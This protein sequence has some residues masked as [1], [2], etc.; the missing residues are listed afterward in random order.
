MK[1]ITD[2]LLKLI[3]PPSKYFPS[4]ESERD[5]W[6]WVHS[7]FTPAEKSTIECVSPFSMTSQERLV[8]LIRAVEYLADHKITG[9]FVECGV[10]K[11]G[12]G[13]AMALTLNRLGDHSRKIYLYD[14]FD[15]M[16]APSAHDESI[17]GK[18]ATQQMQTSSKQDPGS[19]WCYSNLDEVRQNMSTT[20]Y[21][22][23]NLFFIE[24]KVE[25]TIPRHIPEEIALLRLDT[26][27]YEST[28]HE[29]EHLFPRLKKGGVLIID[30]YGHWKG[31][32]RAVDEYIKEKDLTLFLIRIDYTGR[33]AMKP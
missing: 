25:E 27:W 3:K 13:M 29:L 19:V 18:L 2:K 9:D 33:M 21:P 24:G 28:K 11:G 30:D 8:N 23:E 26:D 6:K 1:K 16:S 32:R 14:T 22:E 31:C 15:G 17:D 4:E 12:S 20:R 7:D 5:Y 10:W